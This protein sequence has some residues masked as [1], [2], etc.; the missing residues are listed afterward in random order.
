MGDV[1]A[2]DPGE[3]GP[4]HPPSCFFKKQAET[5]K[6][7]M[8]NKVFQGALLVLSQGAVNLDDWVGDGAGNFLGF[9]GALGRGEGCRG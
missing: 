8:I 2:A 4:G 3:K 5:V 7:R 6:F 1:A 9:G